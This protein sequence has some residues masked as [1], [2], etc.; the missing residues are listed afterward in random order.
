MWPFSHPKCPKC[1]TELVPNSGAIGHAAYKCPSCIRE[2]KLQET[3]KELDS[4]IAYNRATI[5]HYTKENP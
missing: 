3:L 1:K 5:R 2:A 4:A